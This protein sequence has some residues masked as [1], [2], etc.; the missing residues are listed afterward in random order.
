VVL[1]DPNEPNWR[2]YTVTRSDSRV[3]FHSVNGAFVPGTA[4]ACIIGAGQITID[5][6]STALVRP[7]ALTD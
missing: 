2:D 3:A 5:L 1:D 6:S 7:G 4:Y